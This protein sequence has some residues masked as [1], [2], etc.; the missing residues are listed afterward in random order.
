MMK[1]SIL[2][3]CLL[4]VFFLLGGCR[5]DD[6]VSPEG[7]VR[8]REL[9]FRLEVPDMR[10]V[11]T[12]NVD[13]DGYGIQSLTLLCFDRDGS[14]LSRVE[15][16][17]EELKIEGDMLSGTL[18]KSVVP[19]QT[20]IVHFVVN[21]NFSSFS[22]GENISRHESSILQGLLSTSA[23]VVY[24]GRVS[25]VVKKEDGTV[26]DGDLSV[27]LNNQTVT[28]CRN[29]AKITVEQGTVNYN[30]GT[31]DING[32]VVPF[33]V[34]G[35]A[36]C[37]GYAYGTVAPY[38]RNTRTFD[39]TPDNFTVTLP[40]DL[41]RASV[42]GVYSNQNVEY[43]FENENPEA[44][45]AYVVIRGRNTG[46]GATET[47]NLYYRIL[48]LDPKTQDPYPIVRNYNYCIIIT[49]ELRGGVSTFEEVQDASFVNNVWISIDQKIPSVYD[50]KVTLSV[51]KTF[52]VN[53]FSEGAPGRMA[54]VNFTCT[55]IP[56]GEHPV[57][58]W[59]TNNVSSTQNF[60][61]ADGGTAIGTFTLDA[62]GNGKVTMQLLPLGSG[63]TQRSGELMIKYGKLQRTIKLLTVTDFNFDPCWAS[64][65]VDAGHAGTDEGEEVILMF[66]IPE[67]F[68]EELLP[69]DVLISADH[70]DANSTQGLRV[71]YQQDYVDENGYPMAA[72]G[73]DNGLG[74]KYVY[75]VTKEAVEQ[76]RMQRLYLRTMLTP[77]AKIGEIMIE[78]QYFKPLTKTFTFA[79]NPKGTIKVENVL[80]HD[81]YNVDYVLVPAKKNEQFFIEFTLEGGINEYNRFLIF[82][83]YLDPYTNDEL[84]E[85]GIQPDGKISEYT[86]ETGSSGRVLLYEPIKDRGTQ[87]PDGSLTLKAY[88][89]TN[90]SRFDETIRLA[91]A[92]GQDVGGEPYNYRGTTFNLAPYAPFAFDLKIEGQKSPAELEY[93]RVGTAVKLSFD[94]QSF[95][96]SD[97]EIVSPVGREFQCYINAP[98]LDL[99]EN[100]NNPQLRK[101][102]ERF[103]Y[104]VKKDQE[105]GMVTLNFVTSAIVTEGEIMIS[106][107]D[108][109]R[110]NSETVLVK[111]KHIA[112][113][114]RTDNGSNIPTDAFVI[115]ENKD[116]G[117]RIG[118]IT[119]GSNG[120]YTL[121]LRGE[122]SYSW[123][124]TKMI[125]RWNATDGEYCS[126]ELTLAQIV[127]D[128]DVI[129]KKK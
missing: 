20:Q 118:T 43:V 5:Q 2:L 109:V 14:Y 70:L 59:V 103:V 25:S 35:M 29:M 54:T 47:D 119:M 66:S 49:G 22:D 45:Q 6:F 57:V 99:P 15:V 79:E 12:R 102:G 100:Y 40:S 52:V 64:T 58:S 125:M 69:L 11:S 32:F 37:N 112:G 104:T 80:H 9:V 96:A 31:E 126:D 101:E 56:T 60:T 94:L 82:T 13:S 7:N 105:L 106:S 85:L 28:L 111:N 50:G 30:N 88:M 128:P 116:D 92:N 120:N 89:K 10:E 110:F 83:E 95:E 24:W 65:N 121:R 115:F 39:W 91:T 34:T 18:K 108:N 62:A 33:E 81:E 36:F 71:I 61:Y 3:Y 90:T 68:P 127:A 46:N 17:P 122:Y 74:Y 76:A 73:E 26:S 63:R 97:S 53:K 77:E 23:K 4:A 16:K 123:T 72:W 41:R 84:T 27:K 129:L 38:N 78:N 87:N 113:I 98:M 93:N 114:L 67:D 124:G 21:Q 1:K 48:L 51:E 107:D 55:G 86:G 42:D 19:G 117:T 8:E 44:N 75:K